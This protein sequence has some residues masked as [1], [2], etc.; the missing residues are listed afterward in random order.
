MPLFET[1]GCGT[2]YVFLN[3]E[4]LLDPQSDKSLDGPASDLIFRLESDADLSSTELPT[5]ITR[6]GQVV[7]GQRNGSDSAF[8]Y[9][10]WELYVDVGNQRM[11]VWAF[12]A[13]APEPWGP[14]EE[15]QRRECI[16]GT[17]LEAR[18]VSNLADFFADDAAGKVAL[19]LESIHDLHKPDRSNL[20]KQVL[21]SLCTS[22]RHVSPHLVLTPEDRGEE[23]LSGANY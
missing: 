1:N 4:P 13:P 9:T 21:D 15:E 18:A 11:A 2:A 22:A 8:M 17:T 14:D 23:L 20:A 5:F 10:N 6:L 19:F 3:P 7:M 12:G 16:N